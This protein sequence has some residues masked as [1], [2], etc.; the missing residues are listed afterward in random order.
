MKR[1]LIIL[2]LLLALPTLLI[3]GVYLWLKSMDPEFLSSQ[4]EAALESAT[5]R[6]VTISGPLQVTLRPLPSVTLNQVAIR[7]ARWAHAPKLLAVQRLSIRPSLR[8]ILFGQVLLHKVEIE[9][10]QV[11]LENSLDG[12]PSWIMQGA[13]SDPGGAP[14]IRL[15][16]IDVTHLRASY[17]DAQ[18]GTTRSISLDHLTAKASQADDPVNISIQGEI[19][20]LP[21]AIS[22]TIGSPDQIQGGEPFSFDLDSSLGQTRLGVKGRVLDLDFRDYSGLE[23]TFDAVGTRPVVLMAWTDLEIPTMDQFHLSGSLTGNG[24]RLELDNLDARIGDSSYALEAGGRITDLTRLAG[25]SLEFE[26]S[27][28][29]PAHFLT[30]LTGPFL[31]TE[32]YTAS[33]SLAGS[34]TDLGLGDLDVKAQVKQTTLTLKGTIGDLAGAGDLDVLFG[35]RGEDMAS[36]SAFFDLPIPDV[37]ELDGSVRVTGPWDEIKLDD[38]QATLREGSISGELGGEIGDLPDLAG[39]DLTLDI[40]GRDLRDVESLLGFEGLPETNRVSGKLGLSGRLHDMSVRADGL[41]MERGPLRLIANGWLLDLADVPRLDM[42]INVSGNNIRDIT[43]FKDVTM[44]PTDRFEARGRLRGSLDAPDLNDLV[45]QAHLGAI[46]LEVEGRLPDVMNSQRF[47][48]RGEIEGDDLSRLG[49]V[50]GQKWPQ[51][52]SFKLNTIGKGTW[53]K[54][55]LDDVAGTLVTPDMDMTI[56]GRIGDLLQPRDVYLDV[57]ASSPSLLPLLPWGGHA[58]ERLGAVTTSFSL[59]GGPESFELDLEQLEAGASKLHGR[60]NVRFE[61]G[62]MSQL[63][64]DL[65]DSDLDLTPW[66]DEEDDS[67]SPDRAGRRTDSP[68]VFR[69]IPLPVGWME[70]RDFDLGM[71]GLDLSLGASRLHVINGRMKVNNNALNIDPFTVGYGDDRITG[72]IDLDTGAEPSRLKA[73]LRSIDFDLGSLVQR[74]GV[75]AELQGKMDLMLDLDASGDSPRAMA[76]DAKGRFTLLLRDGFLGQRFASLSAVAALRGLLPW[77]NRQEGT[78]LLCAMLD[79]PISEGVATSHV[80]VMDTDDMLMRG[81]GEIDLGQERYD[82][83]LRPRPKRNRATGFNANVRITGALTNPRYRLGTRDTAVKAAGAVGRFAVL[84]PLGLFVSSDSFRS[85]RQECA[86]SLEEVSTLN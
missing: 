34:A 40:Q 27:G 76:N 23:A 69:E 42:K 19:M 3:G 53:D 39:M 14:K 35:V 71:D 50:Y 43:Y 44:P 85:T 74:M 58:W 49:D 10:A 60:F 11:W 51:T 57:K 9:G 72:G 17:F 59:S 80:M 26:S 8:K 29:S 67:A 41:T 78:K 65:V 38:I 32:Q 68:L 70:G 73:R 16:S 13:D 83:L 7:N 48:L 15:Q 56:S 75:S 62:E 31:A 30:F 79:L 45:A 84:G 12:R 5:G 81:E 77:D 63:S 33:G 82:L 37:D 21:L 4:L 28:H 36:V 54:P 25:M 86:E 2:G 66:L 46:R 22:G 47:Q 6:E 20:D 61:D 1:L 64:G 52:T 24:D 18:D 55:Q